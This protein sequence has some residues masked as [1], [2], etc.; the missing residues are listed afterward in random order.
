MIIDGTTVVVQVAPDDGLYSETP[1]WETLDG[2]RNV[3]STSSGRTTEIDQSQPGFMELLVDNRTRLVDLAYGPAFV[4]FD[5]SGSDYWGAGD[6]AA[7]SGATSLDIRA[8]VS[9]DDWTPAATSTIAAQWNTVGNLRAWHLYVDTSGF[10]GL[11]TSTDGAAAVAT[12]SDYRVSAVNGQTMCVRATWT[13]S[14]GATNFY[15]KRSRKGRERLDCLSHDG[16]MKVGATE[17]GGTGALFNSTASVTV[18]DRAGTTQPWD[19]S[20]LYCDARTTIGSDTLRFAF[21]PADAASSAA[22]SWVASAGAGETWTQTG[23]STITVQ[24]DYFN[25]LTTGTPVRLLA[26]RSAVDYPLAYGYLRRAPQ[27]FPSLGKDA[28]ARL[29]CTDALGFLAD[30]IAPSTPSQFGTG[31]DGHYWPLH[32]DNNVGQ[33]SDVIGDAPGTW[34]TFRE[35]GGPTQP[36]A[37]ALTTQALIEGTYL[38]TDEAAVCPFTNT[39]LAFSFYLDSESSIFRVMCS[40]GTDTIGVCYGVGGDYYVQAAGVDAEL[41]DDRLSPGWHKFS[42][43]STGGVVLAEF[44]DV[45]VTRPGTTSSPFAGSSALYLDGSAAAVSDVA[46]YELGPDVVSLGIGPSGGAGQTTG[47]RMYSLLLDT[48]GEVPALWDLTTDTSTYLG[49]TGLGV[50]YAELC[51]QVNTAEQGRFHQDGDG[52]LTFRSRLWGMTATAATVSQATFGDDTGEVPYVDIGVDPGS[53]EDVINDVTVSLPNG[54]SGN[55]IDAESV[56]VHGQRSASYSAPLASP[57]DAVALAKYIV[58]LRSWPQTRITNLTINP[59]GSAAAWTQV[60]TRQIGDRI[61][62]NRR[63]TSTTTPASTT[64]PISAQVCIEQIS[65]SIDRSGEWRTTYLTSPAPPTAS[66]AGYFTFDDAVLGQF[67]AGL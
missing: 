65:H 21:W 38:V 33:A 20:I 5:G 35:A 23:S 36:G 49:P 1:V 12:V 45:E 37:P 29:T 44:D 40:N 61:T 64:E 24:G 66:E 4:T 30:Q 3:S 54:T 26:T 11:Q 56:A 47:E 14:A 17:T 22:T 50:S 53:R 46:L 18:G 9:A 25:R 63:T 52:V 39:K 27:V 48:M 59:A 55:Y 16:W 2:V 42:M 43:V 10:L 58:G 62:V 67:D 41:F 28:V 57:S 60:L 8:A 34:S 7:F 15:V 31:S 32:E 19:G 6:L 51:R 13:T